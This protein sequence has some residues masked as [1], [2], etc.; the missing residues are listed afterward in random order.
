M[1]FTTYKC[2][3]LFHYPCVYWSH[4]GLLRNILRVL[5]FNLGW[6][7]PDSN[8]LPAHHTVYKTDG[9]GKNINLLCPLLGLILKCDE[10]PMKRFILKCSS[11]PCEANWHQTPPC[12]AD[13]VSGHQW[14]IGMTEQ[15]NHGAHCPSIAQGFFHPWHR[16]SPWERTHNC[17]CECLCVHMR[18]GWSRLSL[19]C[20]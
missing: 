20:V 11:T 6:G 2:M 18:L 17:T 15:P 14:N 13:S 7:G 8:R 3:Q 9:G 1:Y 4:S 12:L 16:M 5:N 19:S 10:R